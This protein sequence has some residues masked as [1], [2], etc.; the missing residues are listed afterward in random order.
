MR[1]IV[2]LL[3][4]SLFTTVITSLESLKSLMD[5]KKSGNFLY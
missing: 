1:E 4:Y 3:D 2:S 5:N